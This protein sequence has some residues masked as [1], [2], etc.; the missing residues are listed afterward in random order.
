MKFPA[1]YCITMPS[2]GHRARADAEFARIGLPVT[3]WNGINGLDFGLKTF[4]PSHTDWFSSPKIIGIYLAHWILWR[5]LEFAD[6][7]IDTFMVLEDDVAFHPRFTELWPQI[8]GQLPAD[9][10]FCYVGACCVRGNEYMKATDNL[11][12]ARNP[13]ATHAY[14]F[15]REILATL[16]E[17]C[18]CVRHPIDQDLI[19]QV[20]HP[21]DRPG[22]KHYTMMPSLATQVNNGCF[23]D[24]DW[25][26]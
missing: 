22:V 12:I 17:R 3:Y 25:V 15:K 16:I 10:Q 11:L 8:T 24:P 26:F 5:C 4:L 20:M 13:M 19:F 2:S 23:T 6:P 21:T 18:A 7:E 1:T 9:W 14:M